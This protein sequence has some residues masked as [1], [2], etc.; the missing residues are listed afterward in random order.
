MTGRQLVRHGVRD[1]L[2]WPLGVTF[3]ACAVPNLRGDFA[4]ISF[5]SGRRLFGKGHSFGRD[6]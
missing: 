2:G 1:F 3:A 6:T 4:D 5:V